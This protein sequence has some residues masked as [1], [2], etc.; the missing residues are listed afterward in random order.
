MCGLDIGCSCHPWTARW[1]GGALPAEG[2]CRGRSELIKQ[3]N[4]DYNDW[5]ARK[6]QASGGYGL[7][8]AGMGGYGREAGK[9]TDDPDSYPVSGVL[10]YVA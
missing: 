8:W 10:F 9:R 3:I 5:G 7:V 2:H 4:C 6:E 1:G